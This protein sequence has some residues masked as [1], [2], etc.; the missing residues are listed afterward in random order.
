MSRIPPL[1][2]LASL[3]VALVALAPLPAAAQAQ[4]AA[5]SPVNVLGQ[6]M[7]AEAPRRDASKVCPA[8]HAELPEALASAW[9]RVGRS[10]VVRLRFT[11]EG[12]R[13]R[14]AVA[15]G[16]PRAYHRHLRWAMH[17]VSCASD[18]PGVQQFE[19]AV[20]FADPHELAARGEPKVAL[21]A[22]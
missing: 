9:Q 22:D 17:E 20:R 15:L 1:A 18:R 3:A 14:E 5:S 7:P 21:L 10:A 2:P 6:R 4:P 16:G 11:L 8:L 12:D 19:I 13:V